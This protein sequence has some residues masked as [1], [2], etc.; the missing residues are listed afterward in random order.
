MAVTGD[1]T[2]GEGLDASKF[3]TPARTDG[4][5]QV[6]VGTWPLYYFNN[7]AAPGDTNGQEVGDVWYVV[8]PRVSPSRT[9]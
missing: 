6:K 8:S 4:T 9:S 2:V 1:I 7:D 5:K 3:T